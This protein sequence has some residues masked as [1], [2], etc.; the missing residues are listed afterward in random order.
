[1]SIFQ[2]LDSFADTFATSIFGWLIMAVIAALFIAL[3]FL[4]IVIFRKWVLSGISRFRAFL[5]AVSYAISLALSLLVTMNMPYDRISAVAAR[6]VLYVNGSFSGMSLVAF[7]YLLVLILT[8]RYDPNVA[9][10]EWLIAHRTGFKPVPTRKVRQRFQ[11]LFSENEATAHIR[12]TEATRYEYPAEAI[13]GPIEIPQHFTVVPVRRQRPSLPAEAP[14]VYTATPAVKQPRIP[15]QQPQKS[16][17][18]AEPKTRGRH[19][20]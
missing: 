19:S 5:F 8:E 3:P 13:S 14:I 9:P 11:P 1:M 16:L 17:V 15:Q 20:A 18:Q 2:S 12:H 6:T 7:S 4:V 10:F